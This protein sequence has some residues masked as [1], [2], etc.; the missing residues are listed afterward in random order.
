MLLYLYTCVFINTDLHM[1]YDIL[2]ETIWWVLSNTCLIVRIYSVFS[3]IIA[4]E[5]CSYWWSDISIY[6]VTFVY[7]ACVQ[8]AL[9]WG[10]P[11]QLGLQELVY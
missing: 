2:L 8:I 4:N 3:E 9:I 10:F 1:I 5:T 7:L 11:V 6:V